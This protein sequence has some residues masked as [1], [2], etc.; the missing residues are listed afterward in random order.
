MER[1][2]VLNRTERANSFSGRYEGTG[3]DFK[4]YWDNLEDL[5]KGLDAVME[6]RKYLAMKLKEVVLIESGEPQ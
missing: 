1:T 3:S 2:E 6:G 4:I 5:K